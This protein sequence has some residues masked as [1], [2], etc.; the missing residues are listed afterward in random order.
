MIKTMTPN[1]KNL[2]FFFMLPSFDGYVLYSPDPLLH[3]FKTDYILWI[4]IYH[5]NTPQKGTSHQVFFSSFVNLSPDRK[6]IIFQSA[7]YAHFAVRIFIKKSFYARVENPSRTRASTQNRDII[8]CIHTNLL[9][10]TLRLNRLYIKYKAGWLA[11]L[12]LEIFQRPLNNPCHFSYLNL[13]CYF[14]QVY[15]FKK[16]DT[17]NL[18]GMRKKIFCNY[19]SCLNLSS[20]N[21]CNCLSLDR[22]Y[23]ILIGDHGEIRF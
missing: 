9:F 3:I 12:H 7:L 22:P 4:L 11:I 23:T 10:Y 8:Y 14:F 13:F 2:D 1:I 17:T 6:V 16:E 15:P 18:S 21:L 5:V 19:V 20:E